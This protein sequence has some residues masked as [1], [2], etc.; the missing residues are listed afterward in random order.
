M[1]AH[2]SGSL[3]GLLWKRTFL[4]G[5]AKL[6]SLSVFLGGSRFRFRFPIHSHYIPADQCE[7]CLSSGGCMVLAGR[8]SRHSTPEAFLAVDGK[9]PGEGCMLRGR[10]Q[11]GKV[12]QCF[13]SPV[14]VYLNS[15]HWHILCTKANPSFIAATQQRQ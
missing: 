4:K 13:F 7:S 11:G 9:S 8:V 1:Y 12:F 15:A 3:S 6:I 10:W 2:M 14:K 5:E